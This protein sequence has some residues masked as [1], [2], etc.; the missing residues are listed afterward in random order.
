MNNDEHG[1]T[2]AKELGRIE[3]RKHEAR[4]IAAL[5]SFS[6][7]REGLKKSEHLRQFL[8][9]ND[10]AQLCLVYDLDISLL[11]FQTLYAE[12]EWPR[13]LNARLLAMTIWECVDDLQKIT[14]ERFRSAVS[15]LTM[16]NELQTRVDKTMK[17]MNKFKNEHERMLVEI[18]KITAAHRDLDLGLLFDVM[19]RTNPKTLFKLSMELSRLLGEFTSVLK[20]VIQDAKQL[21]RQARLMEGSGST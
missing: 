4:I 13:N 11:T 12:T 5:R 21:F 10:A 14:G 2:A 19:K 8:A 17:Q 20:D 1:V 16:G 18:R 7:L 15:A 3:T 9:I 6:Q